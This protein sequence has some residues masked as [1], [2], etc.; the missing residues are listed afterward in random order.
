MC[1]KN[2]GKERL[3]TVLTEQSRPAWLADAIK[4]FFAIAIFASTQRLAILAGFTC[5]A[6]STP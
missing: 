5:P 3:F 4:W 1:Q 2:Y 6:E